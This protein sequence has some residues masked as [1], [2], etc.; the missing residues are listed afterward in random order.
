MA[1]APCE[2]IENGGAQ[3]GAG[4]AVGELSKGLEL[5]DNVGSHQQGVFRVGCPSYLATVGV[6]PAQGVVPAEFQAANDVLPEFILEGFREGE[7]IPEQSRGCEIGAL[8]EVI[9]PRVE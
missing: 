2:G 9:H 3:D 7:R 6:V 1:S 5:V 4:R 8:G